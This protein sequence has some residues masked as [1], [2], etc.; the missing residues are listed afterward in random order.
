VTALS[1]NLV[2][3][4]RKTVKMS[5]SEL[6][7]KSNVS[8]TYIALIETGKRENPSHEVMGKIALALGKTISEIFF[9]NESESKKRKL[10]F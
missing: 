10:F 4:L 3:S 2:K 5:Q 8:R 6:A 1:N 7:T 9:P